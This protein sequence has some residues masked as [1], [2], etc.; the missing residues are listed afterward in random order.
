MVAF[1]FILLK[2]VVF[3]RKYSLSFTDETNSSLII[4]S[5]ISASCKARLWD[6]VLCFSCF[7]VWLIWWLFAMGMDIAY[8]GFSYYVNLKVN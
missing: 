1:D 3:G 4:F 7:L 2:L 5:T 6:Q 8:F